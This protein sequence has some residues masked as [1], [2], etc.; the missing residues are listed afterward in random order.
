[1]TTE[2]FAKGVKRYNQQFANRNRRETTAM[3]RD[4]LREDKKMASAIAQ[5]ERMR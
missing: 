2:S 1:M 3:A 5:A 4:F